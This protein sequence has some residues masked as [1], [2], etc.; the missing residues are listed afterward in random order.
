[1]S[2][3]ISFIYLLTVKGFCTE[4]WKPLANKILFRLEQEPSTLYSIFLKFENIFVI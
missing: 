3:L 2:T 4:H 1:M